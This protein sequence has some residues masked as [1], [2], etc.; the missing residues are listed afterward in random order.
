MLRV[1]ALRHATRMSPRKPIVFAVF[2]LVGAGLVAQEPPVK[3][4]RELLGR[5]AAFSDV[6]ERLLV[7]AGAAIRERPEVEAAITGRLDVPTELVVRA[8]RG[9]WIQ[10][11]HEGYL[12]WLLPGQDSGDAVASDLEEQIE[13]IR[14]R[15]EERR[16]RVEKERRRHRARRSR[17]EQL[18]PTARREALGGFDVLTELDPS[19]ARWTR[20]RRVAESLERLFLSRLGLSSPPERPTRLEQRLLDDGTLEVR[21]QIFLFSSEAQYRRYLDQEGDLAAFDLG[22]HA[23]AGTAALFLGADETYLASFVHEAVHLLSFRLFGG[24]LP[25]W[26]E[27]GLSEDLSW[28]RIGA[29]GVLQ[30]GTFQ[31]FSRRVVETRRTRTVQ[32]WF[33][34]QLSQV[35][36]AQRRWR[37]RP[38]DPVNV[39]A[40]D[41]KAFVDPLRRIESYT[42]AGLMTRALLTQESAPVRAARELLRDELRQRWQAERNER[43]EVPLDREL[44]AELAQHVKGQLADLAGACKAMRSLG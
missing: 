42:L 4:S 41:F 31:P 36:A 40:L 44:A 30:P 21:D 14:V 27:E 10:V 28:S 34:G 32:L 39:S 15:A 38:P 12:G 35:C 18:M 24:R 26:L 20:L 25:D 9:S 11:E 3:P 2:A 37:G 17:A 1:W 16:Q 29:D 6:E 33:P 8:R 23:Q 13:T 5:G 7:Q 43:I 22:G 19:D